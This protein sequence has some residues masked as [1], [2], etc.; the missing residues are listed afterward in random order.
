MAGIVNKV[1][2]RIEKIKQK[3]QNPRDIA[4]LSTLAGGLVTDVSYSA[5]GTLYI[6][7]LTRWQLYWLVQLVKRGGIS[8]V[9]GYGEGLRI[10]R[11]KEVPIHLIHWHLCYRMQVSWWVVSRQSL[12]Q[13]PPPTI[14][15]PQAMLGSLCHQFSFFSTWGPVCRLEKRERKYT[16]PWYTAVIK[17]RG[18]GISPGYYACG[19]R[20]F[21]WENRRKIEP[22]EIPSRFIPCLLVVFN[23]QHK[24]I[25]PR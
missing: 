7:A 12:Q 10:Y 16:L 3:Q 19:P 24:K 4:P 1:Y 18:P 20:L 25:C 15:L 14:F 8:N 5:V 22:N 2:C 17:R 21:S 6:T 13:P 9:L 11:E 23:R